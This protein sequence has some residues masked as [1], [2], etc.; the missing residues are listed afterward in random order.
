VRADADVFYNGDLMGKL[1]L[2]KWQAA[3]ATKLGEDMLIQSAV[4][5]APLEITDDAVFSKV[6][7]QLVFGGKGVHLTVKANVDANTATA[8]GQFVVRSIPAKG[9]I[10]V[11]PIGQ[12]GFDYPSISDLKIVETTPEFL[13]LQATANVTNPT[14]YSAHVPYVNVSIVVNDT[15]VG[16]AWASADVVPGPNE[17][18]VQAAWE[19]SEI[20]REWLSQFVSGHNTSFTIKTHANSVPSIPDI[21]LALEVPTPHLFGKFLKEATVR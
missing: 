17:I 13:T 20:G 10:F 7:Q 6:V 21:G 5:E 11:K 4:R 2:R 16:Y 19:V 15:R 9:K 12:G 8:L 1:D 3:N 14:D 18:T